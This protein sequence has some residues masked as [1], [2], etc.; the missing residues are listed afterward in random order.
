[1]DEKDVKEKV[2]QIGKTVGV[3]DMRTEDGNSKEEE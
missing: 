1:M 2:F 3:A